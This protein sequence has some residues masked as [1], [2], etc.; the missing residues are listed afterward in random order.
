MSE[1]A[2][3]PTGG[4]IAPKDLD[5]EQQ[6]LVA[7]Y[8]KKKTEAEEDKKAARDLKKIAGKLD[9]LY[10][11]R[12]SELVGQR[13]QAA[14]DSLAF[15]ERERLLIDIGLL[16]LDLVDGADESLPDRILEEMET[17]GSPNHYYFSEWLE[18]RFR[19]NALTLQMEAQ[20]EVE[21]EE[22]NSELGQLSERRKRV[23]E[24]LTPFFNGL[25]GVNEQIA[26]SVLSGG[27]DDQIQF[28]GLQ[29]LEEP[30]RPQFVRRHR[31][32]TLRSSVLSKVR[33][34][35]ASE[36][37]FKLLDALD[38]LYA[39]IW[40]QRYS[41][42]ESEGLAGISG[43]SEARLADVGA[44]KVT[45]FLDGEIKFIKSLL[46]L[47]ALAG[48]VP[49]A[50]SVLLEDAQRITKKD[51]RCELERVRD[52]DRDFTADPVV[53]IAPFRG[54]GFFEWD[55]DSLVVPLNPVD[56]AAD[57]IA[58]AS[59]N[60]RMLIDSFQQDG[61]LKAAYESAFEG[62]NFQQAFQADYRA[63]VTTV[64][65]GKIEGMEED[66]REFFCREI[67]PDPTSVPV[68]A[69]LRN[70]G[71]EARDSLRKRIGKQISL[72]A[73][74]VN[75]HHRFGVLSW[76]AGDLDAALRSFAKALSLDSENGMVNYSLALIFRQ[77]GQTEKARKILYACRSR[78][79][80]TIWA[81]YA[82]MALDGWE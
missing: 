71:P 81:V 42:Y 79:A 28:S 22:A 27:L 29:L 34:R 67:G 15:T 4:D 14:A 8:R 73:E 46:P 26:Q 25:P 19:R 53:L 66:H 17:R 50:C 18:D 69:N 2:A 20:E 6:A 38:A 51:T 33:A 78:A 75:L 41:V 49:R 57:S 60:Y 76:Q 52:C 5:S 63:W 1:K 74:D 32:N 48:G 16:D 82:Q 61:H 44:A 55:R 43:A 56:G 36:R 65:Y 12:V 11:R 40:K 7:E 77:Q 23:L 72:G 64:G 39:R 37:D 9:N 59:G 45:D 68:P 62:T 54:R 3:S 35:L 31:L 21:Q 58:H 13:A 80:D 24:K 10:W 70:L 47:G 30:S